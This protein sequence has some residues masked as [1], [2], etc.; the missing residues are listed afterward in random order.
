ML[1]ALDPSDILSRS[2]ST[3]LL[4]N[5]AYHEHP[6]VSKSHL[7]QI[8]R[9]P[10]HYWS[11]YLDPNRQP[12]QPTAAMEF[13]TAVHM[14]VLEPELFL[15]TYAEAPTA[16]KTTKA[17]KEAWAAAEAAGKV[18]LKVDE[19]A[20]IAGIHTSIMNHPLA[21]KALRSAGQAEQSYITTDPST[22]LEI[23]CRPDY[24]TDS[25]W[26]IDLKTTLDASAQSFAKSAANFRYHVQA[27]FYL[28]T[29]RSLHGESPKGFL[30]I[31]VEKSA[32]YAVQVFRASADMLQVG[33]E[34]AIADLESLAECKEL[35]PE[36]QPWP[37]Y[38]E[39]AVELELPAWARSSNQP[40]LP[41][42]KQF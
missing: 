31:A 2:T 4:D 26:C 40:N 11:R 12:T 30:F 32:P 38:P 22:G 27:A 20:Q 33:H 28:H 18:L 19:L 24:L 29:L 3:H 35:Y 34:I 41:N 21:K 9:S 23:K 10:L 6:A 25:G 7:D 15:E 36:N 39:S 1:T 16:S 14:A 42:L 5:T 37:G 17:G 8:N 13:G